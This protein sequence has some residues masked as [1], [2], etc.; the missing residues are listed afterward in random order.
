MPNEF[1]RLEEVANKYFGSLTG[2]AV[3]LS[4]KKQTLYTYKKRGKFG[5]Q[6]LDKLK[7]IGIN[8]EYITKG[9]GPMLLKINQ[10]NVAEVSISPI[11]KIPRINEMTIDQLRE[12]KK[13]IEEDLPKIDKILEVMDESK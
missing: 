2:I 9:E 3:L 8:P 12:Y 6:M 11:V 10:E 5:R 13:Q 4:F 7:S 1:N